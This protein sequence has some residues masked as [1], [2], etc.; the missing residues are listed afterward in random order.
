MSKVEKI[1]NSICHA[2]E[3][4][5]MEFDFAECFTM[6]RDMESAMTNFVRRVDEGSIR[7]VKTYNQFKLIL[8]IDK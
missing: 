1:I 8:D 7:S 2:D 4:E 3:I 5:I 6:M